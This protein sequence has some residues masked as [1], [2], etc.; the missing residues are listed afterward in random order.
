MAGAKAEAKLDFPLLKAT[1]RA[2]A[3]DTSWHELQIRVPQ[4]QICMA[5]VRKGLPLRGHLSILRLCVA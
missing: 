4:S 2:W 1:I 5:P 3:F